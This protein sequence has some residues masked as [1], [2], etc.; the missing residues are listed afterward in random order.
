[1]QRSLEM[2]VGMLG[3]LKAGAAYV[4][5]DPQYPS[6]RLSF[7]L[8]DAGV[9]ALLTT[10]ALVERLPL[11]DVPLVRL[12]ADWPLIA[13]ESRRR[14]R[15]CAPPAAV[16][17]SDL[18]LRLDRDAERSGHLTQQSAVT[19]VHWAHTVYT[20]EQLQGVL[21]STSLCFDLSVFELLVPFCGGGAV[22]L[23]ENALAL[24]ELPAAQEVTLINTVPSAMAELVRAGAVPAAA[25]TI[26]L[27]WRGALGT[28]GEPVYESGRVQQVWNLYGPSEDTTYSTYAR[29]RAGEEPRDRTPGC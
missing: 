26:N 15:S 17:L 7:M 21:A 5:L 12:D 24:A 3:I 23:A 10:E 20:A 11:T 19:L 4:P 1:M 9:S 18:H 16:G 22:I 14:A 25:Q 29:C 27:G 13:R 28:A 8:E 2:V 6:E